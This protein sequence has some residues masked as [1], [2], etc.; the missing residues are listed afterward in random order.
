VAEL[1]R[2]EIRQQAVMR[3]TALTARLVGPS[4]PSSNAPSLFSA[5]NSL[6]LEEWVLRLVDILLWD[7]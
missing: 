1:T 7:G 5:P 4:I 3:R 2:K 6:L